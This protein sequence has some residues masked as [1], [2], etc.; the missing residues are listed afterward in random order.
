MSAL[1]RPRSTAKDDWDRWR[2]EIERLYIAENRPL[3]GKSG[4]IQLMQELHGFAKTKCQ[5]ERQL[6]RWGF[7]KYVKNTTTRDWQVASYKVAKSTRPGKAPPRLW[8]RDR[9]VS[10]KVL[11]KRGFM[12]AI[13]RAALEQAPS[14]KTPPGFVLSMPSSP[15]QLSSPETLADEELARP[16][17]RRLVHKNVPS[18]NLRCIIDGFTENLMLDSTS[19]QSITTFFSI[20]DTT[21]TGAPTVQS[22]ISA[23][24]PSS[25]PLAI[26]SS[27]TEGD[28]SDST[29]APQA[30][31]IDTLAF[32]IYLIANNFP[33]NVDR[34]QLYSC[35]RSTGALDLLLHMPHAS[36][37]FDHAS[38]HYALFEKLFPLAVE[39]QD[40]GVV[41]EL[42]TE[43]SIDPNGLSC[44]FQGIA[45]PLTPLEFACVAGNSQMGRP[46]LARGARVETGLKTS[47]LILAIIGWNERKDV[48]IR[49]MNEGGLGDSRRCRRRS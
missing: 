3:K 14:L 34:A 2:D 46:P 28:R 39:A 18:F 22:T 29:Q 9:L 7:Q 15:V 47:L 10:S 25:S 24:L 19:S 42:L 32:A 4:V 31:A 40:L 23:F 30:S 44:R 1:N 41:D 43:R 13:E 12:T 38:A 20:H 48:E 17:P 11:N 35:I 21:M 27:P 33:G 26:S 16:V 8:H 36:S 37:G 45:D 49:R 6:K 5:Y